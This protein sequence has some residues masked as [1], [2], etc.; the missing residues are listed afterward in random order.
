[1]L[2]EEEQNTYKL[3]FGDI[4]QHYLDFSE[5]KQDSSNHHALKENCEP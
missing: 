1:M 3:S 5:T 4:S 2:H